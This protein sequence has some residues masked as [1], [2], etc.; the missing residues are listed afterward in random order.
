M[1][2]GVRFMKMDKC[3]HTNV[4]LT[5]DAA[6]CMACGDVIKPIISNE[7]WIRYWADREYRDSHI[8]TPKK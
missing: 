2:T 3:P 8:P 6:Y 1:F 7:R 4:S 5:N